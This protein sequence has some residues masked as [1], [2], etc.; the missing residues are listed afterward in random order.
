LASLLSWQERVRTYSPSTLCSHPSTFR[1]TKMASFSDRRAAPLGN[2]FVNVAEFEDSYG[3][4]GSES[5]ILRLHRNRSFAGYVPHDLLMLHNAAPISHELPPPNRNSNM[6]APHAYAGGYS[7]TD[8]SDSPHST[9]SSTS[10]VSWN[11]QLPPRA[12]G[13]SAKQKNT[14]PTGDQPGVP[15]P[16][17]QSETAECRLKQGRITTLMIRNLPKIVSQKELLAELDRS[18]FRGLYDFCYLPWPFSSS[19]SKGFGF[20]NF[21]SEAAARM[22]SASWHGQRRFP[23]HISGAGL[24]I[25]PASVQGFARNVA[26]WCT[27]RFRRI[28]NPDHIPFVRTAVDVTPEP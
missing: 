2:T 3:Q 19:E 24:S 26:K 6:P 25:S 17:G 8:G 12:E 7:S 16:Q 13:A 11:D 20:V 5:G 1:M 9:Q 4:A 23:W 14:A 10:A 18:G 27:K 15:P 28:R 21:T 22:F